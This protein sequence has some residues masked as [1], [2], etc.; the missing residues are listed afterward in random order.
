MRTSGNRRS[1]SFTIYFHW[2]AH[3]TTFMFRHWTAVLT[4]TQ[5]RNGKNEQ[6]TWKNDS[7]S[8]SSSSSSSRT[9]YWLLAF[10][11]DTHNE[12]TNMNKLYIGTDR[13][14]NWCRR[15]ETSTLQDIDMRG[16]EEDLEVERESS[17]LHRIQVLPVQSITHRRLVRN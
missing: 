9:S 16:G 13:A 1:T 7:S 12:K 5:T 15:T 10:G 8:S 4:W 11:S 2:Q 3:D 17:N 14:V 6:K